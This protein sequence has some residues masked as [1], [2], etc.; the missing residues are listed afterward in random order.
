MIVLECLID[1]ATFT[2]WRAAKQQENSS[3]VRCEYLS[4]VL[5]AA[6]SEPVPY[7]T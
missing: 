6:H 1:P 2:T 3:A 4:E 7:S 5:S